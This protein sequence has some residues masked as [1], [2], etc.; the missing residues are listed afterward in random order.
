MNINTK[1]AAEILGVSRARVK[2]FI[3]KGLLIDQR[4]KKDGAKKHYAALNNREVRDFSKTDQFKL[5]K[6][7]K[8]TN[9]NGQLP[10]LQE[11]RPVPSRPVEGIQSALARIE[12]KLDQLLKVWS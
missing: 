1:Q 3:E 4:P 8:R 11:I 6:A 5:L 7:S 12:G 10:F 2:A 9:G